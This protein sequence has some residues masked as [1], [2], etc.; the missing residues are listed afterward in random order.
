M[1]LRTAVLHAAL[2]VA[3][4]TT[5]VASS[6]AFPR[7]HYIAPL[8]LGTQE[9]SG[10][11][12]ESTSSPAAYIACG[13]SMAESAQYRV[14]SSIGT[15]IGVGESQSANYV[16]LE[17]F[18]AIPPEIDVSRPVVFGVIEPSGPSAGGATARVVGA[19]FAAAG[20]G[21]PVVAFGPQL[22]LGGFVESDG[23]VVLQTPG[24]TDAN[25]T[26]LGSLDVS[27][28]NGLGQSTASDAYIFEP[29]LAAGNSARL[30]QTLALEFHGQPGDI[31]RLMLGAPLP[32]VSIPI[33]GI[34]GHFELTAFFLFATSSE[35]TLSGYATY[36][37]PVPDDPSLVGQE[38]D[39]QAIRLQS[40]APLEGAFTNRLSTEIQP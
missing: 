28:A 33:A 10:S 39:W 37:I 15:G 19:G 36:S 22:A 11:G 8:A 6:L 3:I 18:V 7:Y 40:L 16:A 17:G 30:G 5:A 31:H 2:S 21:S 27:L 1:Q 25:G 12:S 20:S 4:A 29:A 38:V 32:G 26:A 9:R 13:G 14:E 35:I 23:T 34:S 24:G